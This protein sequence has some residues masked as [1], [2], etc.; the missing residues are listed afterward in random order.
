MK[1]VGETVRP[2]P[3]HSRPVHIIG[4]ATWGCVSNFQQLHVR[5][6]NVHYVKPRS[7]QKGQAPLE[8]NHTEFIF[9]D[10]G[11]QREYGGE[12]KFRADLE[13]AI[14]GTFFASY[15]T[16]KATNSLQPLS[17]T[18]SPRSESLGLVPVVLLVVEGG[19]NTVRTV[20]EA[21]VK[22]NIPAVFIQG[23]GRCCDLF[24][25]AL[26]VYDKYLAHAKSSAT[27]ANTQP[28]TVQEN[29]DELRYKLQEALKDI[30][31]EISG[32]TTA[33]PGKKAQK[34]RVE[35]KRRESVTVDYFELV[36]ECV[37]ERRNFLS[38]VSL[39]PRDPVEPDIDVAILKALLNATSSS[40]SIKTY[41]S[42]KYEQFRLALEW[43]RPDIVK[44]FIMTDDEDWKN[45]L[46]IDLFEKALNRKQTDFVKLFLDH[47]FPL[48]NLY[49][50]QKK[51]FSLYESSMEKRYS[52][53]VQNDGPLFTIYKY[54]IQPLIGDI[55]D[56]DVALNTEKQSANTR[57]NTPVPSSCCVPCG[58]NEQRENEASPEVI[59][60]PPVEGYSEFH[61][62]V[63][64]E[65]FLWS[66]IT[67]RH[68]LNLLFWAR[69]K[70]KI[71]AALVAA[72]VYRKYAHKTSDNSY[73][74]KADDFEGLAV[75][76]LDRFH[77]SHAYICTKAIIR[78]IPAYGNVTWL[79]L[80]IKAD[81]KQFI[82][83]R[84]V[85]NVLNNI[86]YGYIDHGQSRLMIILST[87]MPLFSG[88]LR[89]HNKL[90]K[91]NDQPT[92]LENILSGS[93]LLEPIET[94]D[95]TSLLRR[96]YII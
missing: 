13:R 50:D 62:D 25:E 53:K 83:H 49:R 64:K 32:E 45:P 8:P 74:Q 89:Y 69:C 91:T 21:V 34:L 58:R 19:P 95:S 51:L 79:D 41:N 90:V 4:I 48:T 3:S 26:R 16:S 73:C 84:A 59:E 93:D 71:C 15:S 37:V 80:A 61:M 36:Y 46:L 63:D 55:F 96:S 24:A 47:D 56:T 88:F 10:D 30:I 2:N 39:N 82:S 78:Q 33:K 6:S 40:E 23:T 70:N 54:I 11:T 18:N 22:N 38:V 76:I 60:I 85:Q 68:E 81:A 42:R 77:Q 9:I 44:K 75:E 5:G 57:L 17:G 20:H 31:S 1:L 28:T 67:D 7:E 94:P 12:I 35:S 66:V 27:I 65:L 29:N 43:K 72:L 52:I 87:I 92:F 14:A 86:W